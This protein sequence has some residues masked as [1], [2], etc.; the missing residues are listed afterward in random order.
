MECLK[1]A[2]VYR[3]TM[4][5]NDYAGIYGHDGKN[6]VRTHAVTLE[7]RDTRKP[8]IHVLGKSPKA[9]ECHSTAKYQEL[10]SDGEYRQS[11]NND[12]AAYDGDY[13]CNDNNGDG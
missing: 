10:F 3:I 12:D 4:R 2:C 5:A 7:V 13:D 9:V 11:G 1:P 8:V 6:N